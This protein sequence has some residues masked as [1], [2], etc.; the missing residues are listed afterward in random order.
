MK[1]SSSSSS[2]S[3][4]KVF[5]NLSLYQC[6]DCLVLCPTLDCFNQH[7]T[8]DPQHSK[9]TQYADTS[10]RPLPIVTPIPT[11]FDT[12]PDQPT[13]PEPSP[14]LFAAAAAAAAEAAAAEATAATKAATAA[15]KETGGATKGSKAIPG[16]SPPPTPIKKEKPSAVAA[17]PPNDEWGMMDGEGEEDDGN[18][19]VAMVDGGDV[20]DGNVEVADAVEAGWALTNTGVSRRATCNLGLSAEKGRAGGLMSAGAG[21]YGRADVSKSMRVVSGSGGGGRGGGVKR[22]VKK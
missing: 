2:P 3:S 20:D 7:F 6:P 22:G 1:S 14:I 13:S 17:H 21:A 19:E 16:P 10:V 11:E 5:H 18:M 15:A 9:D 4:S 8:A 12:P